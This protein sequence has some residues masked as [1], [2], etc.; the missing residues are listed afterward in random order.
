MAHEID[1]KPAAERKVGVGLGL[2][3][4]FIPLIFSWFTLR[5][6]H[7]T[8]S[9]IASFAWLGVALFVWA[10]KSSSNSAAPSAA[11]ASPAKS[12][13]AQPTEAVQRAPE[14]P[15]PQCPSG[16]AAAG[17]RGCFTVDSLSNVHGDIYAVR[18]KVIS[19]ESCSNLI[20]TLSAM[21]SAGAVIC[22]GNGMVA[23]VAGG[24]SEAWSGNILGC[25]QKPA[26]VS[27]KLSTCM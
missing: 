7:S 20:V 26:N 3:I 25:K 14:P 5:K 22:D 6:G 21:D 12:S 9:K 16:F 8:F 11:N 23:D 1:Q 4:F 17:S 24:K 2:G 18:G 15:S 10:G 19:K 13:S 27:L